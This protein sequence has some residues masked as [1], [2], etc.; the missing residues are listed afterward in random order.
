M[1]GT[2]ASIRGAGALTRG[3]NPVETYVSVLRETRPK[4]KTEQTDRHAVKAL[5]EQFSPTGVAVIHEPK[6]I[7]GKG[8]P[9]FKIHI[10]GQ[11]V[12]YVETKPLGANLKEVLKSEQIVRYL[13][14]S[15]NI[16]ITN[17]LEWV[18]IKD[19]NVQTVMLLNK[20][21]AF[22]AKYKLES[23]RTT[24]LSSLL[25][26][27]TSVA[28]QHIASANDLADA[29]AS[30]SRLLRDFLDDELNRQKKHGQGERL[31]GLYSAFRQQVSEAISISEFSDAFAQTLAY[32]LFLAKLNA[33]GSVLKLS[34]AKQYIP[35]S[36]KLIQELVSFLDVLE[37]DFYKD[38][39]WV[40]NEILSII[41]GLNVA[42]VKES[43]SFKNRKRAYRNLKASNEDEWRLFSRD[44]FIYFYEDYLAQYDVKLRKRR[45]VY[46]TPPP[47]VN[48][49]VRATDD[50]LKSRFELKDGLADHK[51]VTV[52]DFAC[53]TG[54]F[55]VEII[56]RIVEKSASSAKIAMLLREHV[57]KNVFAF[58][59]LIAPYTIAHLKLAQYLDD[60]QIKLGSEGRF[61]IL[62]TNTLEP[63]DPQHN[64]LLPALSEETERALAIKKSGVLVI[65]GNPPYAGHS[66]NKT[67]WISEQVRKYREGFPE[68]NKPGQGK[69][70][71]NDYVKFIRFAQYEMERK[72]AGLVAVITD[73]SYLDNPTF[74]GMRKSLMGTFDQILIIDLHGNAN[75]REK[76]PGGLD[77]EN[78]FDIKQGVAIALFVKRPGLQ[79][80]VWRT[81]I[82]GSRI[83]KYRLLATADVQNLTW[84]KISPAA[85]GYLF[86]PIDA[87]AAETYQ[88]YWSLPQ[89]F[90]PGGD[91][92]PGIVT[93]HDEFAISFTEEEAIAKV[94]RLVATDTEEEA[95]ELFR[96]CS[97]DQWKYG[98]AKKQ[99][100][101]ADLR[102][103]LTSI[104][105]QPFD[106]RWTIWNSNV[107]VHR[108]ERIMR[109]MLKNNMAISVIR[110]ADVQGE[111]RH[112]LATDR[113]ITHHVISMKEVNYLFPLYLYEEGNLLDKPS[114]REN[115]DPRF[116]KWV[117]EL[118]SHSFSPEEI[119]GYV[120][121][122]LHSPT[123]RRAHCEFLRMD[124]PRI[125]F[126]RS[127]KDF[128]R[129]A[130]LG[131][132][133][134]GAHLL[135][136]V[137]SLGLGAYG[138][139]GTND[140]GKYRYSEQDRRIYIN[141]T[142]FFQKVSRVVWDFEIGGYPILKKYLKN[143]KGRT[144][145]LAE[146]ENIETMINILAFTIE[147][148]KKIEHV[149]I[150][151]T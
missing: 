73:N 5:L 22:A 79:K 3:P 39:K 148:M 100:R 20:E 46:Y 101:K 78:V 147:Q 123:Y 82:W 144:L 122:V 126:V 91:P 142:Q 74:C 38:V 70:L 146:V 138:G 149:Y 12:G 25:R 113:P 128:S 29:L 18:W 117:D 109:H 139:D 6:R 103:Q 68:L 13:S 45:G 64:Y 10:N 136:D 67:A 17:Y 42:A 131:Q 69:W 54:T 104:L 135:K 60:R 14:L 102:S 151:A 40:V 105:Y 71:Q 99:L 124:F 31:Y 134:I 98:E 150:A 11:I 81:D 19:A 57:L 120:Y 7:P 84:T 51:R 59:Y 112:V 108:R 115:L 24:E 32:G 119:F 110:K 92:A 34:T 66:Q 53:G 36:F 137:P 50:V 97:Q 133:L 85:P 143:R 35:T 130:E 28:P 41:N 93:T 106:E 27:F 16:L 107:A 23:S 129:L 8:A 87:K 55:I 75:K 43:L 94:R 58:E 86:S 48:F 118:Y 90:A 76:T 33:N 21:Q 121:A 9:D 56:E 26:A 141:D 61:N 49:I 96:L 83:E 88:S 37:L 127:R 145:S 132:K 140:V 47:V 80:G 62:L 65:T 111:W 114:R 1:R 15:K 72:P 30:R 95:R 2:N 44:P 63:L 116:R 4:D 125:P 89:I 52:L 77:D